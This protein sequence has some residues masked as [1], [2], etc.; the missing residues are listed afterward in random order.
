MKIE[1][2]KNGMIGATFAHKADDNNPCTIGKLIR[3]ETIHDTVIPVIDVNG[4][5][6]L[7]LGVFFEYNPTVEHNL[8]HIPV[9]NQYDFLKSLKLS[10]NAFRDLNPGKYN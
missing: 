2:L 4:E 7:C 1:T 5:E 9:S 10:F 8:N 6:K 3:F